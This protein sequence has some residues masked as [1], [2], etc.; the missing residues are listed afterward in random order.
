MEHE[1]IVAEAGALT[2]QAPENAVPQPEPP[3]KRTLMDIVSEL[4]RQDDELAD[5]NFDPAVVIG[6][7]NGKIDAIAVVLGRMEAVSEWLSD[8]VARPIIKKARAISANRDRLR[9]YVALAMKA[10]GFEKLP[11]DLYRV[12]LH[13]ASPG[14]QMT[15]IPKPSDIRTWPGFVRIERVYVWETE[16]IRDALLQGGVLNEDFPGHLETTQ[17]V[18]FHVNTPESL[19]KKQRKK[20]GSKVPT[21]LNDEGVKS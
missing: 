21:A 5:P 11:G 9:T 19:E 12:D 2:V 6:E 8:I 13:S 4:G 18:K 10:S 7:L 1:D 17:Y 16:K 20:R 3:K 15:R 14:L